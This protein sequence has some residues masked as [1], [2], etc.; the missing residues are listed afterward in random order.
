MAAHALHVGQYWHVLRKTAPEALRVAA[1]GLGAGPQT[2]HNLSARTCLVSPNP[3]RTEAPVHPPLRARQACPLPESSA[4]ARQPRSRVG[5]RA[6]RSLPDR[7]RSRV[8]GMRRR[9]RPRPTKP[10][11]AGP[12][13]SLQMGTLTRDRSLETR[14]DQPASGSCCLPRERCSGRRQNGQGLCEAHL[15]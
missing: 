14:A 11:I 9:R 3:R 4:R 5:H 10:G 13:P 6:K 15:W 12:A 2:L 7:W 8:T 1:I